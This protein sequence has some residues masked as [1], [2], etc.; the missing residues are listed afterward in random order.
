MELYHRCCCMAFAGICSL[1]ES[2]FVFR[3]SKAKCFVGIFIIPLEP[4]RNETYCEYSNF[5]SRATKKRGK[6]VGQML[7]H[8]QSKQVNG[9]KKVVEP[10]KEVWEIESRSDCYILFYSV[11]GVV[12]VSLS[13]CLLS[14]HSVNYFE[15]FSQWRA[16]SVESHTHAHT[17]RELLCA[18]CTGL[19]MSANNKRAK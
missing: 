14:L 16:N 8:I 9:A 5:C 3:C 18:K 2:K 6:K 12:L 10:T 4:M 13:F 7:K 11:I 17:L 1:V 15:K 19:H